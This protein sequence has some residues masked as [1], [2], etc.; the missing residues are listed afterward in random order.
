MQSLKEVIE[1]NVT[2]DTALR[3]MSPL[4][5]NFYFG[6]T[7][8]GK[9]YHALQALYG[10]YDANPNGVYVYAGPLRMLA[11]EVYLKMT[12]KYGEEN[13]GFITGD[14]TINPSASLLATTM[15][16]APMSG[17]S[18]IIDEAHWVVDAER[19]DHWTRLLKN[20]E[21]VSFHIVSAKEAAPLLK[22]LVSD[23]Y[24]T[25]E[26]TYTRR[27]A[28]SFEGEIEVSEIP[29]KTAV[30]CFSRN[31]VLKIAKILASKGYKVGVLYGALP[32]NVRKEQIEAFINEETDI[33]VTTDVIGHGINLPI[34]NVIFAETEK[35]DGLFQRE[36]MRWE[37]A[38]IAGRAGRYG[39]SEQGKVY[40]INGLLKKA[41]SKDTVYEGVLCAAGSL[42][43]DMVT[44]KA[45]IGLQRKD[46]FSSS[47]EPSHIM[48]ALKTWHQKASE[49]FDGDVL[50]PSSLGIMTALLEK[51]ANEMGY[52]LHPWDKPG[53]II[54]KNGREMVD[55]R[56]L[57]HK[58]LIPVDDLWLLING[59][60][61]HKGEA[62]GVIAS[63]LSGTDRHKSPVVRDYFR[64]LESI[65][66]EGSLEELE[67]CAHS[68]SELKLS[69]LM[70]GEN[71]KLG[72]LQ[73]KKVD[74]LYSVCVDKISSSLKEEINIS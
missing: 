52:Y 36:L 10:E 37:T 8:S 62:V 33:I 66:K 60:Y 59:P 24:H 28:I 45:V 1:A 58:W 18:I 67:S 16:M 13:V 15:E 40:V 32:L 26:N 51:V 21:Y 65:V 31:N 3:S 2:V 56:I 12:E 23:A 72:Y 5:A 9:T 71:G 22:A 7:N 11:Y 47:T 27:T 48:H 6:P 53:S 17:S 49:E 41:P 50:R 44:D 61:N 54:I 73:S 29:A 42:P 39:L 70:F 30:V 20:A 64:T 69:F 19:G 14:E 57:N 46:I 25:T 74:K 68:L 4:N 43:A 34:D 38:Q 63:W 55:V 35:Y